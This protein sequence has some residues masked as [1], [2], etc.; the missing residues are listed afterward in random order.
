MK[1]IKNFKQ[2]F[3]VVL[4]I[5]SLIITASAADSLVPLGHTAGIKLSSRGA[6]VVSLATSDADNPCRISG[7]E[8]GD[9]IRSVDGKEISGN[10]DLREAVRGCN[11]K[12]LQIEYMRGG[13]LKNCEV[14]PQKDDSGE[15]SIGAFIRDSIAGIGTLT[16]YDPETK[17][18]GALG[19][20]VCDGE[21]NAIIPIDHGSLMKSSVRDVKIGKSGFP[22]ELSGDYEIQSDFATI[23]KN[24]ESGIFGKVQD[25]KTLDTK[26]SAYPI[27]K[28]D[29]IKRGSATILSNVEGDEVKE[30]EIEITAISK[31]DEKTKN[32]VIRV[33][34]PELLSK[35][36]GIVRGMSGSP[37]IQDGKIVG[38]VTHVLVNDPTKGYAI[39]IENMLNAAA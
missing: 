22:G 6:M 32:M 5:L 26:K 37:I 3:V 17:T 18:Y 36:G 8:P 39:F 20:G 23:E 27:A 13:E 34:D 15:Y 11:G 4:M 12:T 7:I 14:T 2:I 38:A 33:V 9:I 25:E 35:T 1:K 31:N 19:H 24:T 16:Y 30:Y 28:S 10:G 29:E 21:T